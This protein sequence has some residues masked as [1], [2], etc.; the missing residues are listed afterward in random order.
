MLPRSVGPSGEMI[1]LDTA[2]LSVAIL[3][4]LGWREAPSQPH[5]NLSVS[6]ALFLIFYFTQAGGTLTTLPVH[7]GENIHDITASLLCHSLSKE[8]TP[9][10]I[11]PSLHIASQEQIFT[12]S[13]NT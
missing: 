5:Y 2:G 1:P 9:H 8:Q 7:L 10:T 3:G 13:L 11:T 6:R 12:P 4:Q